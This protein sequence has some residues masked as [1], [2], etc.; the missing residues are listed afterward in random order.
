MISG[1]VGRPP[2]Q[3]IYTEGK[4]PASGQERNSRNRK[5]PYERVEAV[6]EV[7]KLK[8]KA[9]ETAQE[10]PCSQVNNAAGL[11]HTPPFVDEDD[12]LSNKPLKCKWE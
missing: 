10:A 8:R 3:V 11:C 7:L 9:R 1:W 6:F 12:I 4:T 2:D 5:S